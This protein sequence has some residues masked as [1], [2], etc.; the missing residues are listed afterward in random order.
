MLVALGCFVRVLYVLNF[1]DKLEKAT[2]ASPSIIRSIQ[3]VI[4][5][6]VALH[7]FACTFCALALLPGSWL[8]AYQIERMEQFNSSDGR[9]YL[10][11]FYWTID[12]ASTRGAGEIVASTDTEV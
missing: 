10:Y 1:I 9:I 12:T 6:L 4:I 8:E 11:A 3:I 7:W 2:K 5:A